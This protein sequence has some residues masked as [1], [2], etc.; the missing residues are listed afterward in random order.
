MVWYAMNADVAPRVAKIF[1]NSVAQYQ[2]TSEFYGD[3]L[4]SPHVKI[5]DLPFYRLAMS[6]V[7]PTFTKMTPVAQAFDSALG[8]SKLSP[9]TPPVK[10]TPVLSGIDDELID[11]LNCSKD[12]TVSQFMRLHFGGKM[13]KGDVVELN[14]NWSLVVRDVDDRGRLH[15]V[16]LKNT[17][18]KD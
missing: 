15:G 8:W 17:I 12:L 4:L 6:S 2:Q 18:K 3:W 11:K 13:V 14:N 10:T 5:A 7:T 16:G 9:Q 1:N